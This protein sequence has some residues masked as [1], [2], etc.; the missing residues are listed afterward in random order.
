MLVQTVQIAR[1]GPR[2]EHPD[3]LRAI[4]SLGKLYQMQG[5]WKEAEKVGIQVLTASRRELGGEDPLTL[6]S[7]VELARIW[8]GQARLSESLE[9]LRKCLDL[10]ERVLGSDHSDTVNTRSTLSAWL[11]EESNERS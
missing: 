7:M 6:D 8:K 5:L 1:S 3:T 4:S 2:Q 9:L 11:E 10:Q